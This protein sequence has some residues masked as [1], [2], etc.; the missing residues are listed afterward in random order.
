MTRLGLKLDDLQ[1]ESFEI[2]PAFRG[3]GTVHAHAAAASD[4]ATC[5]TCADPPC[6]P[7]RASCASGGDVCCA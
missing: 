4:N 5:D 2:G 1:V 7:T 3:L 6:K